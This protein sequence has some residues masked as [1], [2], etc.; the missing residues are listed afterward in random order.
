MFASEG[1]IRNDFLIKIF[2]LNSPVI[3]LVDVFTLIYGKQ[4][5]KRTSFSKNN[6]FAVSIT[7]ETFCFV[8]KNSQ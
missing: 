7:L 5:H 6:E 2:H 8:F 4:I 3:Y 1:K